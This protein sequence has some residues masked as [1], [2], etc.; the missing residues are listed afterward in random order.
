MTAN[1]DSTPVKTCTKCGQ[2]KPVTEFTK[3]KQKADGLRPSCKAC[4]HEWSV[5]YYEAT[6]ERQSAY[7]KAWAAANPEKKKAN[8]KRYYARHAEEVKAKVQAWRSK[9][10][11]KVRACD[12]ARYR[13]DPEG[14]RARVA[15]YRAKNPEK[16]KSYSAKYREANREKVKAASAK[17]R[18]NNPDRVRA[19]AIEWRKKNPD[20]NRVKVQNRRS[21]KIRNGGKLSKDIAEKLFVLQ[22]GKCPCCQQPLGGDYHIDHIVPLAL[23][24]TNTDDNVQL[25]RST[26]NQQKHAKHP[27]EF[28]QSRGF[29]L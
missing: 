1:G 5:K 29:L 6:K 3:D 13:G 12:A 15:A 19:M 27:V 26:C 24:G 9:N 18:S 23:G 21:R 28:M 10:L 17:W 14:Q 16:V 20:A 11:E 8:K 25:L 4:K 22:K 7:A 2:R